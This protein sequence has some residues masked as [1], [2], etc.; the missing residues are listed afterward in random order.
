[1]KKRQKTES[2]RERKSESPTIRSLDR[3]TVETELKLRSKGL[4]LTLAKID[5]AKIVT[6]E[7]L[8]FEF[9]V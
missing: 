1:M 7:T 8:Q 9:S 6:Q 3:T 2:V 4:T 5:R